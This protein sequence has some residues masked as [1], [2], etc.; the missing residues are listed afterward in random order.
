MKTNQDIPTI[1]RYSFYIITFF[2]WGFYE[3]EIVE[4]R[5]VLCN[6]I[7]THMSL[8]PRILNGFAIVG[9]RCILQ[10]QLL[11]LQS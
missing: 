4:F 5:Q 1:W 7:P 8:A 2:F 9:A 11:S 3:T 10:G 6:L